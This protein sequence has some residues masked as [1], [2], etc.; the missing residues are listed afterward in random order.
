MNTGVLDRLHVSGLTA[1]DVDLFADVFTGFPHAWGASGDRPRCIWEDV[2]PR[3]ILRHLEG[4]AP[5][6]V[7]PM[8]YDPTHRAGG[9]SAFHEQHRI[10]QESHRLDLWMCRWGCVD[11]DAHKPGRRGQGTEAEILDAGRTIQAVLDGA[12]LG[13][14]I[15]RTR[16]G[17]IHV[18]LLVDDWVRCDDMRRALGHA[19]DVAGV[20][21]DSIYP[22]VDHALGPPGNFVRLPYFGASEPG[23]L[24]MLDDQDLPLSLYDFLKEIR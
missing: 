5:M 6:G 1:E 12:G 8:V 2:T 3:T 20:T 23:R 11:L 7:Y 13:S 4:T 16:S 24:T 19:V 21:I 15:E 22:R 17:G 18:W 10:Y 9:P 14:W